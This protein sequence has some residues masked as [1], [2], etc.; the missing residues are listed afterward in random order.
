MI[1][2]KLTAKNCVSHPQADDSVA[3]TI[4]NFWDVSNSNYRGEIKAVHVLCAELF[5]YLLSCEF[6]KPL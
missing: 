4:Q 1:Q 2:Y 6:T 5:E 3:V